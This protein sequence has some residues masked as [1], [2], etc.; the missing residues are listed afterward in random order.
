[1]E[2]GVQERLAARE[3]E[4]AYSV[5]MGVLQKAQGDADVEPVGPFDGDTAV[6]TGQVALVGAGERQVIGPK[7]P[8]P[9]LHGPAGIAGRERRSSMGRGHVI[10]SKAR[11]QRWL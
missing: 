6:R 8:R 1:Q 2:L 7:R 3:A 9:P 11:W 10:G 4:N 5:G